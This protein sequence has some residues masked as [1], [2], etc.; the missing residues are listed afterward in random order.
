MYGSSSSVYGSPLNDHDTSEDVPPRPEDMYGASKR[1]AEIL[2]EG[3]ARNYGMEFIAIRIP[4]VI[5]PGAT[6]TSSPWRSQ[7]FELTS[8]Q[9]SDI[10]I[11]FKGDQALTLVHVEDL[12]DEIAQL[13][14]ARSLSFT[15]YNAPGE[16]W[17][18]GD[19]KKEIEKLNRNL[20][21]HFGHATVSGFA[22]RMDSKRFESEF[23]YLPKPLKARLADAAMANRS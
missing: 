10:R 1:Y 20:A 13:V 18:L 3:Y 14:R 12:G 19:L 6:Q 22:A 17:T 5:G 4:V 16:T 8:T 21:V 11:P 9:G 23:H 7:I 15:C 2:G